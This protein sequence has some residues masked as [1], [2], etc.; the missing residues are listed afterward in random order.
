MMQYLVYKVGRYRYWANM[1]IPALLSIPLLPLTQIMP[2]VPVE[3][4]GVVG[5]KL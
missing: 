1:I 5:E 2:Y 3:D 4:L